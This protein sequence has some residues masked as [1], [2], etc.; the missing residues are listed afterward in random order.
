MEHR[1]IRLGRVAHSGTDQ[2]Q[3]SPRLRLPGPVITQL[4][5]DSAPE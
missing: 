3:D 2:D 1:I 4:D 5:G